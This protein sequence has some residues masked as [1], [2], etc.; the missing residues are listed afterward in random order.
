MYGGWGRTVHP[1]CVS[2]PLFSDVCMGVCC[3]VEEGF[4]Q[5]FVKSKSLETLT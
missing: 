5:L 1:S 3:H 4:Q 2:V